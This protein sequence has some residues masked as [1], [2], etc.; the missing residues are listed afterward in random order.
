[1]NIKTTHNSYKNT[2][3]AHTV[4]HLIIHLLWPAPGKC[5]H[6]GASDLTSTA[7]PR[8]GINKDVPHAHNTGL[9]TQAVNV[10]TFA[11]LELLED[12]R[13]AAGD[14]DFLRYD[15]QM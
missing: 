13:A 8:G 12:I 6:G 4:K 14:N 9:H 15:A 7:V 3:F 10:A 2:L 11:S 5:S 1:M